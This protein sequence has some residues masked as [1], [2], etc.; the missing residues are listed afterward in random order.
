VSDCTAVLGYLFFDFPVEVDF[1]P[2]ETLLFLG[3][4]VVNADSVAF[5]LSPVFVVQVV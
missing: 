4:L 3:V 5:L 1:F 2:A